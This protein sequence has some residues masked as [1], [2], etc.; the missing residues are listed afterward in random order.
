MRSGRYQLRV[1]H[2]LRL[3][4]EA[5]EEWGRDQEVSAGTEAK[6]PG[7]SAWLGTREGAGPM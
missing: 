3:G 5:S 7:S 2:R 4:A 6:G 1:Q